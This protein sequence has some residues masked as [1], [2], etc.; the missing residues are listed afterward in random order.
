M[1]SEWPLFGYLILQ[2]LGQLRCFRAS[3]RPFFSCSATESCVVKLYACVTI[4]SSRCVPAH[5]FFL[6]KTLLL[7]RSKAPFNLLRKYVRVLI[8]GLRASYRFAN[9]IIS[10][11]QRPPKRC[12]RHH[13][14]YGLAPFTSVASL[15]GPGG[16][17]MDAPSFATSFIR[18][19][20]THYPNGYP[21]G[22]K[23]GVWGEGSEA[24]GSPHSYSAIGADC[25]AI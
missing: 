24:A 1:S 10:I 4:D 23:W 15:H 22:G 11:H 2:Y 5:H 21:L 14:G 18:L 25:E 7:M 13:I 16:P 17:Y 9:R 8:F 19:R 3:P 12:L 6:D 20:L